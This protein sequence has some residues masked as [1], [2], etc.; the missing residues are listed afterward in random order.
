VNL[1]ARL[2]DITKRYQ[3]GIVLDETTAREVKGTQRLREL[4][5]IQVRGRKRP[6]KIFQVLTENGSFVNGDA[7]LQAYAQGRENMLRRDFPAAARAFQEALCLNPADRPSA[8]MLE[9]S[10]V[11]IQT[12]PGPDWSGV[13]QAQE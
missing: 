10:R 5:L 8:L 12:P 2:Q 4:D 1:A 3:V 6:E 13:W 11:L 7:V 9:R